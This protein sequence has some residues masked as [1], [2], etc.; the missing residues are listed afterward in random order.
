MRAFASDDVL[1]LCIE[2]E[3]RQ[4]ALREF[5]NRGTDDVDADAW[6]Q[7]VR[8]HAHDAL[9]AGKRMQE[10]IRYELRIDEAAR[11]S[12]RRRFGALRQRL[13]RRR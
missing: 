7:E 1:N 12:L 3:D 8:R 2:L 10:R 13:S 5:V 4:E 9:A 11:I 6:N